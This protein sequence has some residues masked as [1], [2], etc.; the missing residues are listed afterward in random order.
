MTDVCK[1]SVPARYARTVCNLYA[2]LG[3][4]GVSV[5]FSSGDNGVGTACQT[6]DGTNRTRFAPQYPAA[7]PWVTS[8]GGTEHT[9]PEQATFFSSGGF[10]DLW[11]RPMYQHGAVEAYLSK[12]GGKWHGLYNPRGRGFPDVAAQSVNYAVYENGKLVGLEGTSCASPMFAGV[13]G[14]LNDARM[15]HHKP[16][17]GFLNPFLYTIGRRGLN[18][19]THGGSTGCDG[20]ARFNG[21]P[22]GSPVVPYASWNATEGWDPVT[23]LGTPDFQKLMEMAL[24]L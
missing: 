6:N 13:V 2:Q 14:L 5:L 9:S 18:D 12:L 21:P 22:N 23:G 10:S 16:S 1:Q 20:H 19:V 4:R 17:M 11:E 8:V 24:F 3:S 15:R 7:C